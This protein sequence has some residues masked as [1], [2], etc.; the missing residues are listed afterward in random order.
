MSSRFIAS[1][2]SLENGYNQG[3]HSATQ[4]PA[5]IDNSLFNMNSNI[6]KTARGASTGKVSGV[7]ESSNTIDAM[8]FASVSRF[9]PHSLPEYR[10]S[11][12]NGSPYNYS[13]TIN[14]AANIGNGSTESSESRHIQGINSTGNLAE[15]NAGG[16]FNVLRKPRV[17]ASF[18]YNSFEMFLC[19]ENCDK[20]PI[21]CKG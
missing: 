5:F 4:L 14:M 6:H 13:S 16:K 11:L 21:C 15:F 20:G 1:A 10:D 7:F 17:N 18:I 2:G 8:K 19:V 3:F 12:A 9:H